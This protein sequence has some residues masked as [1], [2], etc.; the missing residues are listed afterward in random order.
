MDFSLLTHSLAK[1]SKT[2]RLILLSTVGDVSISHTPSILI[3][4]AN[5]TPGTLK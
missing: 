5:A 1:T 4:H 3:V 2:G